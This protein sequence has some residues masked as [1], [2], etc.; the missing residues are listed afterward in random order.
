MGLKHLQRRKLRFKTFSLKLIIYQPP[1]ESLK[2][3]KLSVGP[4]HD[5]VEYNFLQ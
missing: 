2:P 1:H 4:I 5:K 3:L